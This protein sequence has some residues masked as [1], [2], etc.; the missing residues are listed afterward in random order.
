MMGAIYYRVE[1]KL[2]PLGDIAI[3]LMV[4]FDRILG[5]L[6]FIDSLTSWLLSHFCDRERVTRQ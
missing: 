1:D 6:I 3:G 2:D 4:D 5:R